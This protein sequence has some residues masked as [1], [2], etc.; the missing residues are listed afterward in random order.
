MRRSSITAACASRPR[1]ISTSRRPPRSGSRRRPSCRSRT[2]RSRRPSASAS[3]LRGL[4]AQ[5][6]R[7]ATPQRRPRRDGLPDRRADRLCRQ[8]PTTTRPSTRSASSRSTTSSAMATASRVRRSSRSTTRSA[9][10]HGKLTA[11]TVLM[12]VGTDFGDNYTPNDADRLERGPRHASA[13]RCSSRSTS[14]RSR[15]WRSTS[16]ATSSS[17]PRT[18]GC[19]SVA[20][21][22]TPAWPWRS[23]R[24]DAAGRPGHRLRHDRQR[25]Q[26][27][28][29]TI[30]PHGQG[31][32]GQGRRRSV[33]AARADA[34]RQPA[35]GL[36]HRRT[37]WPATRIRSINPFWGKFALKGPGGDR[38]PATL[39]TGTNND[40]KDLNA[41]G[42]I[43]PPTRE[44]R[45]DGEYALVVGAW[46]GNSDNS[47][48][49]TPNQP[50]VLD[51]RRDLRLAGLPPGDDQG[52]ADPQLPRGRR[53]AWSR[54]PS[55]RSPATCRSAATR[56]ST[57]GSSWAPSRRTG[58]RATRA[59]ARSS[60]LLAYESKFPQ[61]AG[62]GPRLAAAGTARP[63]R[64]GRSRPHRA[65]PTST[66]TASTHSAAT[67][68]PVMGQD[69]AEPTPEPSCVPLPTPDASGV[70]PSF[71]LPEP[72]GDAPAAGRL[73]A[74][75]GDARAECAAQRGA[76]AA[77]GTH[78]RSDADARRRTR[79]RR[80]RRRRTPRR[81]RHRTAR[82]R[83][84]PDRGRAGVTIELAGVTVRRGGRTILGPLDWTVR[85]GERWAVLG[86]N[87]SGKTTLL[88]VV[89]LYLW[90]TSGH[91]GRARRTVRA[92]GRARTAPPDR[93]RRERPRSRDG[94]GPQPVAARAQRAPRAH[95]RRGGTCT[96]TQT[97]PAP[98]R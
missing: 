38:R 80:R 51:R 68:G 40:A 30:D 94:R 53:R 36:H 60:T 9:S 72:S 48:V 17:A 47:E 15:P 88:Q 1:S 22:A 34:G 41:Y 81:R 16:P 67:W 28:G 21:R 70:I 39:K 55:T 6:R 91:G 3:N 95:S 71:E 89:S 24:R 42:F 86:P 43:A 50:A 14:R 35:G 32:H 12:D 7:Q 83:Q 58:F 19:A 69:C 73:P 76:V 54:S 75:I 97:G 31:P 29:H 57:N 77:T 37:S 44:Q 79:R 52:L 46:N 62:V 23:A 18:S 56:A 4:D 49:S 2:T 5:P 25:R 96:T 93:L 82:L 65:S 61:L 10:T 92:N 27:I 63:G 26:Y 33:R 45:K 66:T 78:A 59:V 85:P 90:P 20:T 13:T 64:R 74:R 8:R 11:G 98:R 87:G 84:R